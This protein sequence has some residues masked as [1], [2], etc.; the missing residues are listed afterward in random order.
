MNTFQITSLEQVPNALNHLSNQLEEL[1][2]SL[3]KQPVTEKAKPTKEE[4]LTRTDVAK[5]L[6]V[7]L[8]TLHSWTKNGKVKAYRIGGRVLFRA[9]EIELCLTQIK[10]G[11]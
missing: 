7:S 5:H 4:L 2:K 1:T 10:T 3:Q 8:P 11:I 6:K 9:S